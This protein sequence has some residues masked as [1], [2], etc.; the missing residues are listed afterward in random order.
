MKIY[1]NVLSPEFAKKLYTFATDIVSGKHYQEDLAV[2][3]NFAWDKQIVKDSAPVLCIRIPKTTSKKL[4]EELQRS[5]IFDPQTDK[6]LYEHA[7]IYVWFKNS[8]IPCHE[9]GHA[10]KA[11]TIYLNENWDYNEGGLF[12]WLDSETNEWKIIFPNFNTAVVNNSGLPHGITPVK[13]DTQF[14]V[15]VQ[16]FIMPQI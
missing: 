7:L 10:S 16:T 12:Q 4:E 3:T 6:P 14:R 15:T 13:S 2:W 8:Y 11:V 9:D 1:K 5:G